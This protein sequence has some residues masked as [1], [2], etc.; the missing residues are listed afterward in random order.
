[1]V[2]SVERGAPTDEAPLVALVT[3]P[4][5]AAGNPGEPF[6]GRHLVL[7]PP[8]DP[9][10][11]SRRAMGLIGTIG[12]PPPQA[13]LHCIN[14]NAPLIATTSR[15]PALRKGAHCPQLALLGQALFR[16]APAAPV[17]GCDRSRAAGRGNRAA[18][19]AAHPLDRG[20]RSGEPPRRPTLRAEDVAHAAGEPAA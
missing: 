4:P 20:N 3:Q 7:H 1:M 9:V 17:Q 16:W 11:R 15:E 13:R 14:V 6:M 18:R 5:L 19:A 12:P 10:E 8:S 2:G